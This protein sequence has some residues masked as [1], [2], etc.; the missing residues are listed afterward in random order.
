MWKQI[1]AA[2]IST[3]VFSSVIVVFVLRFSYSIDENFVRSGLDMGCNGLPDFLI[4][5]NAILLAA[6]IPAFLLL[7][8]RLR[9]NIFLRFGCWF[10]GPVALFIFISSFNLRLGDIYSWLFSGGTIIVYLVIYAI[11]YIRL[12]RKLR[13]SPQFVG[14]V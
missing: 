12:N 6:S 1:S 9:G 8:R 5:S 7:L 4:V 14:R 10:T 13:L 11:F 3:F 2:L